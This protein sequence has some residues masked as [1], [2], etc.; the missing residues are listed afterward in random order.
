ML[1]AFSLRL[2]TMMQI[3]VATKR[4][5][6]AQETLQ[7][8]GRSHTAQE[9]HAAIAAVHAASPKSWSLDLISGLPGMTLDEWK[10]TLQAGVECKPP[11][12]S[13]YDLQVGPQSA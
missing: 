4:G 10:K 9:A 6:A 7:S 13:V 1:P 5:S 8:C 3:S 2:Q 11:H 12:M